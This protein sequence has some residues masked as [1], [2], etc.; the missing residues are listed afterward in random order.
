MLFSLLKSVLSRKQARRVIH[1]QDLTRDTAL[2]WQQLD[3]LIRHSQPQKAKEL[4][5]SSPTEL[6]NQP[7]IRL[8]ALRLNL[9]SGDPAAYH[10]ALRELLTLH[11]T[12][13]PAWAE[14]GSSALKSDNYA[15]AVRSF[16]TLKALLPPNAALLN[17]L[18]LAL[19]RNQK[20][21]ESLQIFEQA[22]EIDGQ[23]AAARMNLAI[24]LLCSGQFERG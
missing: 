18:G 8:C 1:P 7:E 12:C 15:E 22:V 6:F 9:A 5:E 4:L 16:E 19:F 10:A 24:A 2:L 17:N 3:E 14:L 13:S 23:L 20:L 11:P 21:H